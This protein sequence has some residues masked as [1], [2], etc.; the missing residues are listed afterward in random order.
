M[1]RVCFCEHGEGE[2]ESAS[3]MSVPHSRRTVAARCRQVQQSAIWLHLCAIDSI[4]E[5]VC[6][7][8]EESLQTPPL[9]LPT[10]ISP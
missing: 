8:S 6:S 2:G 9:H 3:A 5:L 7:Q 4:A 10:L 1:D